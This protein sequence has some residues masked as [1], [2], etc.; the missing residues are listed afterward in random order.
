MLYVFG[1]D[2]TSSE[3]GSPQLIAGCVTVKM[4]LPV[5]KGRQEKEK[6]I[7]KEKRI[8]P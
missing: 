5:I 3:K 1:E 2:I 6:R 8:Y 7:Q 4:N